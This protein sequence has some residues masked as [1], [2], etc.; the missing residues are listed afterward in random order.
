MIKIIIITLI[1]L[2]TAGTFITP[3]F[4]TVIYNYGRKFRKD[5]EKEHHKTILLVPVKREPMQVLLRFFRDNREI[6][7]KSLA[8]FLI[9]DEYDIYEIE[10]LIR[11]L[12]KEELTEN[13]VFFLSKSSKNKAQALNKALRSIMN[14]R[15]LKIVVVDIDSILSCTAPSNVDVVSSI[16]RGYSTM[17]SLLGK[18]QE[19]GYR[20]F[21]K[22]L[23]GLYMITGWRPTLGSGLVLSSRSLREVGVFNEDV[24]LEDVEYSIRAASRGYKISVFTNYVINVQVPSTYNTL[25]RQQ[26]RWAYGAGELMRKYLRYIIRR[27]II[28]IYLSQYLS[29]PFQLF[30]AI[31]LY[32][33]SIFH[34][35]VETIL[36]IAIV[37]LVLYTSC[38]YVIWCLEELKTRSISDIKSSLISI[39]RVNMAYAVMSPRIF[40]SFFSG[41][42]GLPFKWIPTPKIEE[43]PPL[44]DRLKM[45]SIELFFSIVLILLLILSLLEGSI[46]QLYMVDPVAFTITYVW[47][48]FRIIERE[49]T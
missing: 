27:P 40:A 41:V 13:V 16:W 39:N 15:D 35:Y 21:M 8:T 43:L 7:S 30:L 23:N 18:G 28:G 5:Y 26:V 33:C 4:Q 19:I 3:I 22:M 47:G 31:A 36:Q 45:Y 44:R 20:L 38:I 46:F 1:S 42:F 25:L 12:S 34:I 29:Y 37:S 11:E 48:T 14:S 6:I 49:L 32:L 9:C 10:N 2:L 24:I 17:R